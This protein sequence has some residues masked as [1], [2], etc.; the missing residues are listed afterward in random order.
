MSPLL[1]LIE[2]IANHVERSAITSGTH[3]NE[4]CVRYPG[5]SNGAELSYGLLL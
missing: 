5:A 2:V 4:A 3:L 1:C